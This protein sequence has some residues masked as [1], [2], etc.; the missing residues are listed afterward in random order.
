VGSFYARPPTEMKDL[1][2]KA[3]DYAPRLVSLI[4]PAP[5]PLTPV[6]VTSAPSLSTPAS[7]DP[8]AAEIA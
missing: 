8:A 6:H 3:K 5:T 1:F 2:K 4:I 7:T